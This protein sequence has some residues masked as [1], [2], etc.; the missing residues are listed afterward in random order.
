[1]PTPMASSVFQGSCPTS[2]GSRYA[3]TS[4]AKS[5]GARGRAILAFTSATSFSRHPDEKRQPKPPFPER[6]A[7]RLCGGLLGGLRRRLLPRVFP[8]EFL[9][10]ARRIDDLLLARVERVAGR[11][12][13]HVQVLAQRREGLERISA[14]A[15]YGDFLV[16]EM[17]FGFHGE[18][19]DRTQAGEKTEN[20][21]A[22]HYVGQ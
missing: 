12:D 19:R 9:H 2:P 13:L 6:S 11:A 20:Y 7:T 4:S 17:D 21:P 3:R 18:I 16:F 22:N 1:M 10:A 14:A 8:A 5:A 15:D